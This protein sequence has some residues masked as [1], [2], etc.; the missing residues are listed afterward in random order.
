MDGKEN[1]T[2]IPECSRTERKTV[3]ASQ[4]LRFLN[5]PRSQNTRKNEGRLLKSHL[6]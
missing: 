4:R 2:T 3:R 6:A 5:F 1:V